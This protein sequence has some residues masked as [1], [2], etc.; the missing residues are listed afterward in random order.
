MT[1]TPHVFPVFLSP[2]VA[3][4]NRLRLIRTDLKL[5]GEIKNR[6][7][8]GCPLPIKKTALFL[9]SICFQFAFNRADSKR[10]SQIQRE[11]F[12]A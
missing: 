11:Q 2:I 5:F 3:D 4:L 10:D 7:S 12:Y 9:L 1:A 6:E 8:Q